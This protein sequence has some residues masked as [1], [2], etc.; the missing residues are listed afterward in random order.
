MP[1]LALGLMAF[2]E[3]AGWRLDNTGILIFL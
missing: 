1:R 3:Q 2:K